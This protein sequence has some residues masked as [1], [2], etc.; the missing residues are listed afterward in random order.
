[1]V[2]RALADAQTE[3]TDRQDAAPDGSR[4]GV[5]YGRKVHTSMRTSVSMMFIP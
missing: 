5:D 4:D 2:R 1:M 3:E